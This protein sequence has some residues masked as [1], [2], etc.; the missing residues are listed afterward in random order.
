MTAINEIQ[1]FQILKAKLGEPE[2]EN[3][4]QYVKREVET[5]IDNKSSD[6]ATKADMLIV[7]EEISRMRTE[8][9]NVKAELIKW[10]FVFWI[11]QTGVLIAIIKFFIVK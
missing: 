6:F 11:G 8:M 4:V 1:L 2:A 3:L 7:K 5:Q 10:M 9:A